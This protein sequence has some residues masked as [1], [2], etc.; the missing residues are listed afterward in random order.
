M[1]LCKHDKFWSLV[2]AC[3]WVDWKWRTWK[4]R[5]IKIAGQWKCRTKKCSD[6]LLPH[7]FSTD[8]KHV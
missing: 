2:Q 1:S 8:S 5:T 7:C 4:W 6:Y 3:Q